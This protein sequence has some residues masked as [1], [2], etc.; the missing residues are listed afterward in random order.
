MEIYVF[1]RENLHQWGLNKQA[2]RLL[3]MRLWVTKHIL[4]YVVFIGKS[5]A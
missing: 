2:R 3:I 5:K 4:G 1:G